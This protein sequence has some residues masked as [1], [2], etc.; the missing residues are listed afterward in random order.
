ML[1]ATTANNGDEAAMTA[2]GAEAAVAATMVDKS[3]NLATTAGGYHHINHCDC[4]G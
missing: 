1:A 2:D 3:K 4:S